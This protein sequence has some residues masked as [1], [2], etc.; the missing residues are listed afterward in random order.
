MGAIYLISHGQASVGARVYDRLSVNGVEQGAIV[1]AELLRRKIG[2]AVSRTGSL[3]RQVKTAET[4]LDW[5][6][7]AAITKEDVRWNEYHHADIL[8]VHG[9]GLPEPA[10]SRRIQEAL[11][12]ALAKWVA[13]GTDTP[14]AESWPAF[15]AR[16]V[17]ALDEVVATLAKGENAV[18]F[19]SGGVIGTLAGHLLGMPEVGL[20]RMSRAT[21]NCGITK[22]VAGRS[23]LTLLSFNEHAHFEG[24]AARLLTYS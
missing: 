22:L 12:P 11:D 8:R 4:V 16:I 21:L 13:A 24:R 10:T 5:L 1:G 19:T 17:E 18:V 9:S 3:V 2:F 20:L 7:A 14:C 6:G 15:V 23:G